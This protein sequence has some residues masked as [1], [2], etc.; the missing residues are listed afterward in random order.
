MVG[1][2]GRSQA[3]SLGRVGVGWPL[4]GLWL[5]GRRA[6]A[7]GLSPSPACGPCSSPAP[8][9]A[10]LPGEDGVP[11][12]GRRV[13]LGPQDTER[14]E[15]VRGPCCGLFSHVAGTE[16]SGWGSICI[17]QVRWRDS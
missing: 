6:K 16:P 1:A 9:S 5:Q 7:C 8:P 17:L 3:G 11:P 12:W 4:P 14:E 2:S 13:S 10:A 15:G